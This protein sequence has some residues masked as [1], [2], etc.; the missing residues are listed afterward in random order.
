MRYAIKKA[1]NDIYFTYELL[2]L[3]KEILSYSYSELTEKKKMN[4]N[5]LIIHINLSIIL[6]KEDTD[7]LI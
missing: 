6:K 7:R 2:G 4:N 1:T 5:L 3:D